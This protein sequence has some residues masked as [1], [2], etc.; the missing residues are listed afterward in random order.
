[1][2]ASPAF[3]IHFL[4][5]YS[6]TVSACVTPA[7]RCQCGPRKDDR[8]D[9]PPWHIA[10]AVLDPL[11]LPWTPP[12]GAGKTADDPWSLPAIATVRQRGAMAG[13]TDGGA[14]Q[15]AALGTRAASVAHQDASGWPRSAAGAGMEWRAGARGRAT[16][17]R[18]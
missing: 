2:D 7:G 4:K 16:A 8:P 18:C 9:F 14:G 11:G 5:I 1:M 13:L 6:T 17:P 10:M 12:G 3:P 15:M